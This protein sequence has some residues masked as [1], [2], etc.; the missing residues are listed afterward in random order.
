[1]KSRDPNRLRHTDRVETT[2]PPW[3]PTPGSP[4]SSDRT[5]VEILWAAERVLAT[6]GYAAFTVRAV[7]AAA[8]ITP[9]NLAYHYKTKREL[10]R[11]V[12]TSMIAE[13][14]KKI[15]ESLKTPSSEP[16]TAFAKL[17][18]WL[19]HDSTTP[20][21]SRLFRELWT[22]ALHDPFIK[23]AVE[24]LYARCAM[25][26]VKV[27]HQSYP[28]LGALEA[29]EIAYL[30]LMICEGTNPIYGTCPRR[31]APISKVSKLAAEA[32][33]QLVKERCLPKRAS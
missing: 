27:L 15:D 3:R 16:P 29:K 4:D 24:S 22:M 5:R 8:G 28:D 11:A 19:I 6:K 26:I 30:L 32:L 33:S 31:G 7:A 2:R 23:D 9:G 18:A 17:I 13:Y 12:I 10:I 21:T 1:L 14:S 20:V 25:R